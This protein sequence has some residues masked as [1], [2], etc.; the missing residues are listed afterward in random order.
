M[1]V[2]LA[3]Q[4]QYKLYFE[5]CCVILISEYEV[6][7]NVNTDDSHNNAASTSQAVTQ[8]DLLKAGS[9]AK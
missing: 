9:K 1:L 4:C 6:E 7:A 2:H 3:E 5:H 8:F